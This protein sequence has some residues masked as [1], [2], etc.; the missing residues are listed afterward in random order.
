MFILGVP[1]VYAYCRD[2]RMSRRDPTKRHF[3]I[4]RIYMLIFFLKNSM[5]DEYFFFVVRYILYIFSRAFLVIMAERVVFVSSAFWY[6]SL[7][8]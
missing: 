2:A 7:F 3:R 6:I 8:L 1:V 5:E 4:G